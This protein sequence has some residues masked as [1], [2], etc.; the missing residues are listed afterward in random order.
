VAEV[1]T[2]RRRREAYRS[3]EIAQERIERLFQL[4]AEEQQLHPE[5]SDRYVQLAWQISTR[6]RVRIPRHLKMLF[7]KGCRCYLPSVGT[8]VRLREKVLIATCL[9]CGR[10]TRR[11]YWIREFSGEQG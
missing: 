4:A 1:S 6:M 2:V 9:R 5:R 8:R 11:P 3:K 10:Q 7:C